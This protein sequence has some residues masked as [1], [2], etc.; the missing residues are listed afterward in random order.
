MEI[1]RSL[2]MIEEITEAH[3]FS[4]TKNL[5][6]KSFVGGIV[7]KFGDGDSDYCDNLFVE[8]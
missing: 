2:K 6:V 7:R 1:I 8:N 5:G 4:L 3:N